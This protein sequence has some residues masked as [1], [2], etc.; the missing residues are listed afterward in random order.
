MSEDWSILS[1]ADCEESNVLLVLR[2][3]VLGSRN[4]PIVLSRV[5][6]NG[7]GYGSSRQQNMAEPLAARAGD[8]VP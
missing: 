3:I 7:R 4:L 1:V 6:C 5:H 8:E 2:E